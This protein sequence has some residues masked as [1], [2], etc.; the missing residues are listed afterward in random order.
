MRLSPELVTQLKSQPRTEKKIRK[1]IPRRD[2]K[3]P[4]SKSSLPTVAKRDGDL[5]VEGVRSQKIQQKSAVWR[6]RQHMI[7]AQIKELRSSGADPEHLPVKVASQ[8]SNL[9]SKLNSINE[10]LTSLANLNSGVGRNSGLAPE[11]VETQQGASRTETPAL[12]EVAAATFEERK[13]VV[14]PDFLKRCGLESEVGS[15]QHQFCQNSVQFISDNLISPYNIGSSVE[16]TA[17]F[18][19]GNCTLTGALSVVN[20]K[21]AGAED[22]EGSELSYLSVSRTGDTN[23]FNAKNIPFKTIPFKTI[24]DEAEKICDGDVVLQ[25]VIDERS[26]TQLRNGEVE[27]TNTLA[28]TLLKDLI[29]DKKL[30]SSK[31]ATGDTTQ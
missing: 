19:V 9:E 7:E 28:F 20:G 30:E 24:L 6:K 21:V 8:L 25:S 12:S 27:I 16:V 2:F 4:P 26:L 23:A 17:D 31:D 15:L 22:F 14:L 1:Y 29:S 10:Q 3:N 13:P 11:Y 18:Q 5:A